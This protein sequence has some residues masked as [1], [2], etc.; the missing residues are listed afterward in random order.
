MRLPRF[1]PVVDG[2]TVFMIDK[3]SGSVIRII[4]LK[5][6]LNELRQATLMVRSD[7][8]KAKISLIDDLLYEI[9]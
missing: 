7:G 6:Y 3:P 9:S 4:D 1:T 2:N 8:N 5:A